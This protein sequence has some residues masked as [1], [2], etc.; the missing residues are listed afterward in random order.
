MKSNQTK[1]ERHQEHIIPEGELKCSWMT[2]GVISYK[3]C[4]YQY[5]CDNCPFDAAMR[6]RN[7]NGVEQLL[8]TRSSVQ[9]EY[10]GKGAGLQA[11]EDL[12]APFQHFSLRENLY[13]HPGHIWVN[14]ENP[15]SV[16]IGIDDLAVRIFPKTSVVLSFAPESKIISGRFCCWVVKKVRALP[17]LAP[18]SGT[19]ISVN[20]LLSEQPD[21]LYQDPYGEG[22]LMT[23][24]P[25]NLQRDI[26]K[27]MFGEAVFVWYQQ[28][29]EKLRQQF[30]SILERQRNIVGQTLCDGG[31][32]HLNLH[33]VVGSNTYFEIISKFFQ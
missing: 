5:E 19:I 28:E 33:D 18:L 7:L 17:I 2:A 1:K 6:N 10:S 31:G 30:I 8:T 15:E 14:I 16:K 25:K 12:L 20:S 3:L 21:L 24:K 32:R 13:Y 27:L 23:I 29:T 4:D 11:I 22:W 9:T 26:K